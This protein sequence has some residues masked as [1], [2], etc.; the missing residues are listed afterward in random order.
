[1]IY[2]NADRRK[3]Q[4][5][6]RNNP[7]PI[8]EK[9]NGNCRTT[10]SDLV[11]CLSNPDG[12]YVPTGYK[13][14]GYSKCGTWG[15][16][17]ELSD[18]LPQY[19]PEPVRRAKVKVQKACLS[20]KERDRAIKLISQSLGLKQRHRDD[21]I[22]RGLTDE[23]I[24]NNLF[25]SLQKG[26]NRIPASVPLSFP[27]VSER[28][29]DRYLYSS[30]N[31]YA[32][33]TF[34]KEGLATGLQIRNEDNTEG[35]K[36]IWLK[37]EHLEN[38]ELPLTCNNLDQG[39][40][41][42]VCLTEG[43]LKPYI[44]S[45][46]FGFPVIGASGGNFL[47]S[48]EQ[49]KEMLNH[50]QAKTLWLTPDA[51]DILN[52]HT[53]I[54]WVT[55]AQELEKLGYQ[56]EFVWWDQITKSDFDIDELKNL[57][58]M[59][60]LSLKEFQALIDQYTIN[61]SEFIR[62]IKLRKLGLKY[63]IFKELQRKETIEKKLEETIVELPKTLYFKGGKTYLDS[64]YRH[65][66]PFP[67]IEDYRGHYY[68]IIVYPSKSSREQHLLITT[69]IKHG[70]KDIIDK[71]FMGQGKSHG[72]G[73]FYNEQGK[74]WYIDNNHRNVSTKSVAKNFVDL[75]PR[76][77]GYVW[78][79]DR[80]VKAY[81][82]RQNPDEGN[83]H[84]FE[85]F[86]ELQ[87]RGHNPFLEGGTNFVCQNCQ[88]V[89]DCGKRSGAGF[90]YLK[91]RHTTLQN[92]RI[93]V[94]PFSMPNHEDYDYGKDIGIVEEASQA[95]YAT[96]KINANWKHWLLCADIIQ[97][98]QPEVYEA[99]IKPL[100]EVLRQLM[101][102]KINQPRYGYTDKQIRALIPPFPR[103][104]E[105][106]IE[107]LHECLATQ[108][109]KG[110]KTE[111]LEQ[112]K[113]FAPNIVIP[114][115]LS[116]LEGS[117][118]IRINN[119][120]INLTEK[121]DRFI[122]TINSLSA[123]IYL[124]STINIEHTAKLLGK[125][126]SELLVIRQELPSFKNIKVKNTL[127][128]GVG[129]RDISEECHTRIDEFISVVRKE[130]P[131]LKVLGYK[132]QPFIDGYW[133]LHNR[134]QN[135]YSG[136]RHY[137]SIALP[138]PNVGAIEDEYLAIFENLDGFTEYYEHLVQAEIIQNLGRQR[139]HLYPDQPFIIEFLTSKPS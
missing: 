73:F 62:E 11:L 109:L 15:I 12:Y 51:G 30:V 136:I 94:H 119:G 75:E 59:K 99:V 137:L 44:V 95:I 113:N 13:Y 54:R 3:F 35:G 18:R 138:Y 37:G 125:D 17:K 133:Y 130:S 33:V 61:E 83:C 29:D 14:V 128:D 16:Y 97:H 68:P 36:Y 105:W 81:G 10:D 115:I 31:G 45:S 2:N 20:N 55:L 100:T 49:L 78:E 71:S 22:S 117:G 114:M 38:G 108:E 86:E 107:K 4:V 90:G 24:K 46:K 66:V 120:V 129:S 123:R 23:Q 102:D 111:I 93:R 82:D 121:E 72:M 28:N 26:L 41:D 126:P 118:A 131:D 39:N 84:N 56:V 135:R 21:L 48:I 40:S 106:A 42:I 60:L 139:F 124:D 87:K 74:T 43:I 70:W 32:C 91:A 52:R 76:H 88:F 110:T 79:N 101:V 47:A 7:C 1:M 5:T 92:N 63:S 8:C 57:D 104:M 89:N 98:K 116:I 50:A 85:I 122:E 27:N 103:G 65:E 34:N 19:R 132:G 112:I 67:S 58:K 69:A 77:N 53:Q 127:M 64:G 134:G 6:S 9:T 25:F 80:L 96:R